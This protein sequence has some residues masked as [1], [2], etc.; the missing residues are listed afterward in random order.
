MKSRLL[1]LFLLGFP[2]AAAPSSAVEV[3]VVCP[4]CDGERSDI[5]VTVH[6]EARGSAEASVERSEVVV[7]TPIGRSVALALAAGSAWVVRADAEGF[8]SAPVIV[9]PSAGATGD[10]GVELRLYP[11]GELRVPVIFPR[12]GAPAPDVLRLRFAAAG[13]EQAPSRALGSEL[14]GEI[15]CPL[16]EAVARCVLPAATLDLRLTAPPFAPVHRFA[17]AVPPG[18]TIAIEPLTLRFGATVSGRVVTETGEPPATGTTLSLQVPPPG[19]GLDWATERRLDLVAS[20]ASSDPQGFFQFVG[21]TP[22]RYRL[23]AEAPGFAPARVEPVD[24]VEGVEAELIDPLVLAR[25]ARLEIALDPSLDP[26]GAPWSIRLTQFDLAGE[27]SIFSLQSEASAEGRWVGDDLPPGTYE[28]TVEGSRETS[29]WRQ[30]VTVARGTDPVLVQIPLVEVRGTLRWGDEPL[31]GELWFGTVQGVRRVVFD[32][33]DDGEYHGYLPEPGFW[34]VEWLPQ[35]GQGSRIVLEPVDVPDRGRVRLALEVPDTLIEGEVVD[36][37]G[38]PVAGAEVTAFNYGLRDR[39]LSRSESDQE[40][41]F[42]FRGLR[43]GQVAVKA[44][45]GRAASDIEALTLSEDLEAPEVRLVIRETVRITGQVLSGGRPVVAARVTAWPE[46]G[47]APG[48]GFLQA[49]T[50]PEGYF[51]LEAPAGAPDLNLFVQQAGLGARWLRRSVAPEQL[52]EVELDAYGGTL[53][54]DPGGQPLGKLTL[55]HGGSA[56]P[57]PALIQFLSSAAGDRGGIGLADALVLPG[58]EP[59][60]Y[61]LCTRAAAGGAEGGG[62]SEGYLPPL[63]EL[64]LHR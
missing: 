37:R 53:V 34:P 13:E 6:A 3:R 40:G 22:G 52:V 10:D 50:G 26:W 57:V 35:D 64:R 46:L 47:E 7:E 15:D 59:G 51:T 11:T 58:L 43:S 9:P 44:T 2:L 54:I 18:T 63:G 42:S 41:R 12:V 25:P 62:C 36:T 8:W 17:V 1:V 33:D 61:A 16:A 23:V 39:L 56:L 32:V 19:R 29:W 55:V 24:A 27:R 14:S 45:R 20:E 21:V 48:A 30:P 28:V 31:A 49:T 5:L 4:D 60:H 38:A